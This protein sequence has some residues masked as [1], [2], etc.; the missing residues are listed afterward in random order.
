MHRVWHFQTHMPSVLYLKKLI[1]K[2]NIS[3]YQLCKTKRLWTS[4][5][6]VCRRFFFV[7]FLFFFAY[8]HIKKKSKSRKFTYFRLFC[9]EFSYPNS[10]WPMQGFEEAGIGKNGMVYKNAYNKNE[11]FDNITNLVTNN[12]V[13]SSSYRSTSNFFD[14]WFFFWR[15]FFCIFKYFRWRIKFTAQRRYFFDNK[16]HL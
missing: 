8:S 14:F 4:V 13:E 12:L 6:K 3:T 9:F 10:S 1:S 15:F 16:L 7:I 2:K 5:Q 11:I